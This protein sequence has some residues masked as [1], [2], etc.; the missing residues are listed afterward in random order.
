MKTTINSFRGEFYFLS[1]F[2]RDRGKPTVEHE[3]QA[4]KTWHNDS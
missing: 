1:N 4:A 2:Y 3:F